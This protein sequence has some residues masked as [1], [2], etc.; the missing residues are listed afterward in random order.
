MIRSRPEHS[1]KGSVHFMRRGGS[2][3]GVTR[4][5]TNQI[6]EANTHIVPRNVMLSAVV[7]RLP[8][9]VDGSSVVLQAR[10]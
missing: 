1:G 7:I 10:F 3:Q 5:Q 8:E 6:I 4:Q 9:K 2:L